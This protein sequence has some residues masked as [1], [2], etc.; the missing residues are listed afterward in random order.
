MEIAEAINGQEVLQ[1]IDLSPPDLVFV[2]IKLPGESGLELT[3]R[4]KARNPGIQV[5][6]LT[7]YDFPEY[8]EAASRCG[9][10]HFLS[11]GATTKEEIL[12]LVRSI[13]SDNLPSSPSGFS[14]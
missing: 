11:K 12:A 3:Q 14:A 10:D 4:I 2:D 9:A 1:K 7:S 5:L 8:R 6:I 13:L